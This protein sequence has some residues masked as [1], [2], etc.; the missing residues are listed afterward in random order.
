MKLKIKEIAIPDE[1]PFKNDVLKRKV[2]ADKL[3]NLLDSIDEP[4]VLSIDSPWG[5]GKTTFIRMWEKS[6]SNKCYPTICYNAW[7]N[8]F[9]DDAL[10]TLISELEEG[11]N[12]LISLHDLRTISPNT[13]EKAKTIGIRLAKNTIP[14]LLKAAT[15]G[16]LDI[17]NITEEAIASLSEKIAEEELKKYA[18]SKKT[19]S[20]FR[21]KLE[22]FIDELKRE[23]KFSNKPLIIFIDELDRCRPNFAIEVLEKLKHFFNIP[24]IIFVLSVDRKQLEN[25]VTTIYGTQLNASGY[26]SR[27]IDLSYELPPPPI[28]SFLT[29]LFNKFDYYD[30]FNKRSQYSKLAN[31]WEHIKFIFEHFFKVCAFTL[32]DQIQVFS[33]FTT[34]IK[35][36]PTDH[37]IYGIPFSFLFLLRIVDIKL[38]Y[39]YINYEIGP[40]HLIS[41]LE[42][43]YKGVELYNQYYG[44]A[45]VAFI[46]W[47]SSRDDQ[48]NLQLKELEEMV[49]DEESNVYEVDNTRQILD[50]IKSYKS[51]FRNNPW[52]ILR[53]IKNRIEDIDYFKMQ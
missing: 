31:D 34:L 48:N 4:F 44:L 29:S 26:L 13:L 12:K 2:I 5:S 27:F 24:G 20:E 3:T 46:Y 51:E 50:L 42:K 39:K 40:K 7:E 33:K 15:H 25:S 47:L 19:L 38:Y 1:D 43:N 35:I 32:R 49:K 17:N 23:E 9:S 10:V 53:I 30:Y 37:F 22:E 21:K 45:L 36:V 8:D 28:D 6:L 52:N 16:L 14:A 11:S 18:E 41:I